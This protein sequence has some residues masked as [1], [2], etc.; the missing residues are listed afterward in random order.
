MIYTNVI[1]PVILERI[2]I[3]LDGLKIVNIKTYRY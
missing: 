3:G 1:W 2:A